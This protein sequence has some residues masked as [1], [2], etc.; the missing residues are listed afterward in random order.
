MMS[1]IRSE[2]LKIR[3]TNTW[4]IFGLAMLGVTGLAVTANTLIAAFTLSEDVST[5]GLDPGQA[6]VI[7][8]Q[9]QLDS[10]ASGIFTSGQYFGGLFALLFGILIVTNEFH[11]QTATATFLTTPVRRSVVLAKVV[12]GAVFATGL[13]L[14][15]TLISLVVGVLFFQSRDLGN[16]LGDWSVQRAI[17]F[18]LAVFALWGVM[19]IGIGAL[20]R[21]Q[22]GATIT[23]AV[24]YTIGSGAVV[25]IF[26]VLRQFVIK[27]DWVYKGRLIVP[28][29]AAELFVSPASVFP[30]SPPYW[31]G[32]L[33][34]IGYGALAG[35]IG[36]LLI[37]RRDIS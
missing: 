28:S 29:Q 1:L 10:L 18:N 32:G 36:T 15:A 25:T 20:I 23:A 14:I 22:L 11:H 30:G 35:F 3:T 26:E 7:R 21:S 12:A 8:E 9:A 34:M 16:Q 33:L 27:E 24:L 37:Q 19:G 6:Q 31:V 2:L 13:W 17:L 5:E 4:W